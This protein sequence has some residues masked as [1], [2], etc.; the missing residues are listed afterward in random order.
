MTADVVKLF[1]SGSGTSQQDLDAVLQ[2]AAPVA[3][4]S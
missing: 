1:K 2:Q 3:V 4:K